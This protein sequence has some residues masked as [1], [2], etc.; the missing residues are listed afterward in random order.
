ME[1]IARACLNQSAASTAQELVVFVTRQDLFRKRARVALE[2]ER[3]NVER[4]SP[5]EKKEKRIKQWELYG[6]EINMVISCGIRD[7][8]TGV[9]GE[10]FRVPFEEVYHKI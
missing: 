1:E 6:I 3:G 9:W 5:K 7:E 2:F 8:E 10:R 4:N